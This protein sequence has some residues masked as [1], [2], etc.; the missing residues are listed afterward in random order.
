MTG[1]YCNYQAG[2][3]WKSNHLLNNS[4]LCLI[5]AIVIEIITQ[6]NILKWSQHTCRSVLAAAGEWVCAWELWKEFALK[7]IQ[8]LAQIDRYEYIFIKIGPCKERSL[9]EKDLSSVFHLNWGFHEWNFFDQSAIILMFP[10]GREIFHFH[11][12]FISLNY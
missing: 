8:I 7:I 9:L 4:V 6:K 1:W 3:L 5:E 10:F 11:W 12:D 2:V